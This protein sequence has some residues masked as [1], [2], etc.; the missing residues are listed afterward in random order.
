MRMILA[1][2]AAA[3]ALAASSPVRAAD[4]PQPSGWKAVLIAGSDRELAF[5]NAVDAMALKLASFGVP[6]GDIVELKSSSDDEEEAATRHNI[7]AAF[8]G[9]HP[10]PHDGCFVFVTS[11]GMAGRGLVISRARAFLSPQTLAMLL[12]RS[13]GTRPTV[14]IASGCF[15]GIFTD[16]PSLVASNRA[17]LAAARDD[18][19]SFGCDASREYTVF[20]QCILGNLVRGETWR[21]VM[22]KTRACVSG[23]EFDL[24]V[25]K[26]SDPQLAIGTAVAGLRVFAR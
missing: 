21:T 22:G 11:H 5:D 26:P 19:P 25:T 14:V 2:F 7:D 1:V 23:N 18:R 10:G 8:V 15:S 3:L 4:A 13:C 20:D 12:D 16:G 24:H 17:I 6:P 9:L